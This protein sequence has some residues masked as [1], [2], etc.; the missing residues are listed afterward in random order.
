MSMAVSH[1]VT[2]KKLMNTTGFLFGAKKNPPP[3]NIQNKTQT[4][5]RKKK[6]K[7]RQSWPKQQRSQN[8]DKLSSH[9]TKNGN[10]DGVREQLKI[11]EKNNKTVR[12]R[13]TS[14]SQSYLAL[15]SPIDHRSFSTFAANLQWVPENH[16][17]ASS[18]L[19]FFP[20]LFQVSQILVNKTSPKK[21]HQKSLK[22]SLKLSGNGWKGMAPHHAFRV[23]FRVNK[24]GNT[25]TTKKKSKSMWKTF[26]GR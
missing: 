20:P 17:F 19:F 4:Q 16:S 8:V 25:T 3:K 15:P 22:P 7:K 26:L 11:S 5:T 6:K 13:T 23:R 10:Y 14:P 1:T 18:S 2:R 24:M 9:P 21:K 12:R